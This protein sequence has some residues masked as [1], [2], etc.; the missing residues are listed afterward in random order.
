MDV[1]E[2]AFKHAARDRFDTIL[3]LLLNEPLEDILRGELSFVDARHLALKVDQGR[4]FRHAEIGGDI[5]VLRLDEGD[6]VTI[7]VVVNVFQFVENRQTV[8]AVL[9]V[10]WK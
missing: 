8:V 10:V 3:R 5:Q 1:E 6:A 7:R 4:K 9:F 2:E